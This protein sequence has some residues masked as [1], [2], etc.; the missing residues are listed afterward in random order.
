MPSPERE[1]ERGLPI[2]HS[3]S[4]T[5]RMSRKRADRLAIGKMGPLSGN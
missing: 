1:K 4:S 2:A 5:A 3:P